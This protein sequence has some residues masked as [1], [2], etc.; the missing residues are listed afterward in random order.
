MLNL[1]KG[2]R[3]MIIEEMKTEEVG[4]ETYVEPVLIKH[5][6]LHALTGASGVILT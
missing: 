5:D 6:A 2:R 4:K 3:L 1:T